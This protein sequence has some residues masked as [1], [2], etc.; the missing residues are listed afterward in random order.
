MVLEDRLGCLT[1]LSHGARTI[2]LAHCKITR[3]RR[4]QNLLARGER[5][6]QVYIVAEGV[7]HVVFYSPS[8][9]EVSLRDLD[10]DRGLA[11]AGGG[12]HHGADQ[13]CARRSAGIADR[14]PVARRH[15]RGIDTA[16]QR[17]PRSPSDLTAWS[18]SR[19]ARP[20][21]TRS[22]RRFRPGRRATRTRSTRR[23]SG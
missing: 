10:P 4:R 8:G 12:D 7:L 16:N 9:R 14:R 15:G 6:S 5:S 19:S 2:L 13:V 21:S 22:P 17:S 1:T 20:R 23:A 18:A 11:R 3:V